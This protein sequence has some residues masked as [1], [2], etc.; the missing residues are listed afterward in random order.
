MF[1]IK[2]VLTDSPRQS[3]FRIFVEIIL[4]HGKLLINGGHKVTESQ[5]TPESVLLIHSLNG[6]PYFRMKPANVDHAGLSATLRKTARCRGGAYS[7]RSPVTH[8]PES[9]RRFV[10]WPPNTE[11]QPWHT[12]KTGKHGGGGI[13][14]RERFSSCSSRRG[15]R[16]RLQMWKYLKRSCCEITIPNAPVREQ[17]EFLPTASY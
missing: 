4:F 16:I 17:H 8:K 9:R 2:S 6:G 5:A 15:R 3:L 7:D 13:M 12:V 14:A 1:K 11:F 10:T